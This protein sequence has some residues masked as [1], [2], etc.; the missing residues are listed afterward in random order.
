MFGKF[1]IV[2]IYVLHV[3]M[4]WLFLETGIK[5][6]DFYLYLLAGKT[7]EEGGDGPCQS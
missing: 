6:I 2:V 5:F 7:N 4:Y 1:E 3:C